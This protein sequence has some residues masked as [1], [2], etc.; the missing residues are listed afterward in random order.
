[1]MDPTTITL[2]E[3]L[4]R[5]NRHKYTITKWAMPDP[6]NLQMVDRGIIDALITT[7]LAQCIV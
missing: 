2:E 1:M 7:D 4:D 3:V 6:R 5:E